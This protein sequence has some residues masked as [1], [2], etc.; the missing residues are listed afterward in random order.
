[1]KIG[2]ALRQISPRVE[3]LRRKA[4]TTMFITVC[5]E[6]LYIHSGRNDP[7]GREWRPTRTDLM[8]VDWISVSRLPDAPR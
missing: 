3:F 1:M 8:H 4:W 5:N 7:L 6:A 2:D